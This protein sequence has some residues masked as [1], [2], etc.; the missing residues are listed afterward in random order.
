MDGLMDEEQTF[1]ESFYSVV[2]TDADTEII[3]WK[4]S[5]FNLLMKNITPKYRL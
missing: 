5:L 3:E 4:L 1:S 2:T